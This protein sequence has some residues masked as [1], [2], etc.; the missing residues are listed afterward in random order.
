MVQPL[1]IPEAQDTHQDD[2]ELQ[3]VIHHQAPVEVSHQ[4][5]PLQVLAILPVDPH[6]QP[7]DVQVASEGVLR[8]MT[9]HLVPVNPVPVI[10]DLLHQAPPPIQ[11][12]HLLAQLVA[13]PPSLELPVDSPHSPE[14]LV[15]SPVPQDA[16][17]V[18]QLQDSQA[19]QHPLVPQVAQ[20]LNSLVLSDQVEPQ[21]VNS[22]ERLVA[23]PLDPLLVP[24][25]LDSQD[26]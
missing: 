5:E 11:D 7:Q 20:E 1:A 2:Q 14:L 6:P 26:R 9:T 23:S 16:P 22:P 19:V 3:A 21:V 13:S 25:E 17:L 15:V 4:R 12:Q 10:P 8:V 18:P 24:Q